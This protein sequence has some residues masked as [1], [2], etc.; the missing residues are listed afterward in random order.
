[1]LGDIRKAVV[2]CD[3]LNAHGLNAMVEK[4]THP[5]VIA[6]IPPSDLAERAAA[7]GLMAEPGPQAR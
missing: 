3:G 2:G 4:S 1:M 5:E 6:L 7:T